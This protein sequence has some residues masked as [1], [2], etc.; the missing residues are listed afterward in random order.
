MVILPPVVHVISTEWIAQRLA[1][2]APDFVIDGY[3]EYVTDAGKLDADQ[4]FLLYKA[5]SAIVRS[6]GG[7]THVCACLVLG[8]ADTAH[9]VPIGTRAQFELDVSRKRAKSAADALRSEMNRLSQDAHFTKVLPFRVQGV[10][11]S[12]LRIRDAKT[13]ADMRK[14]RRVEITFG[15]CTEPPPS[16]GA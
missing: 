16:R 8:H 12:R 15:F 7:E 6:F 2:A 5:A 11:S 3:P 13:E 1:A 4:R 10:G 14:N 9:R